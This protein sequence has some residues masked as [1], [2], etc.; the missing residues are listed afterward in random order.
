MHSIFCAYVLRD[1]N[2]YVAP[3]ERVK[4]FRGDRLQSPVFG[5]ANLGRVLSSSAKDTEWVLRRLHG[6]VLKSY[7]KC[8]EVLKPAHKIFNGN[9]EYSFPYIITD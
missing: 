1:T 2:Y 5:V 9:I 8:D 4:M 3:V 6:T 7:C